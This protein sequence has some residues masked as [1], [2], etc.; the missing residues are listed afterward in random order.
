MGKERRV[1]LVETG[2]ERREMREIVE[3]EAAAIIPCL[4]MSKLQLE[5]RIYV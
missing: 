5:F 2:R 1:K 4:S 3:V